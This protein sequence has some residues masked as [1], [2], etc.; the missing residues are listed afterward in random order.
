MARM[1]GDRHA[2]HLTRERIVRLLRTLRYGV[3][4]A[5]VTVVLWIPLCALSMRAVLQI[6]ALGPPPPRGV[7]VQPTGLLELACF[8]SLIVANYLAQWIAKRLERF[9]ERRG[10]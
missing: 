3:E 5:V 10:W 2:L 9:W 4:V 7:S 8:V 1:I 6:L